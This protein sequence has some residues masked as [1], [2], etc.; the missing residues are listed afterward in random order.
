MKLSKTLFEPLLVFAFVVFVLLLLNS[1]SQLSF[2]YK[3][4]LLILNPKG[5]FLSFFIGQWIDLF[6]DNSIVARLPFIFFYSLSCLFIYFLMENYFTKEIDRVITVLIFALLPGLNSAALIINESIIVTFLVL[7]YLYL[8]KITKKQ[9]I[10]L[11]LLFLFIDNSFA[12]FYLALFF[13]SLYKKDNILLFVSLAL[14]G[15][16]M[17]IFGF[18]TGGKPKGY[19]IN[20][21]AIYASIFSPLLFMYF[22]YAMYKI[23]FKGKKSLYWFVSIT[24]FGFS[25]LLSFRQKP[26]IA[27]FAPFVVI[28]IPMMVKLF[29]HSYRVRLRQYRTKHKIAVNIVLT[30]LIINFLALH[31]NKPFYLLLENPTKHFAYDYHFT[32]EIAQKLKSK[33]ID[34][35]YCE[36]EKLQTKLKLYGIHKGN[37]Y[38]I[39][40]KNPISYDDKIDIYLYDK[41]ILRL[42]VTKLNS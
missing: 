41:V 13:Y 31:I 3:E 15:F 21:L 18:D 8:Y 39:T 23:S 14:F 20:T 30:I 33:N 24:A 35:I 34:F 12:I 42:F 40:T 17:S 32:K 27:D 29:M 4:S 22:T 19:F 11:L 10:P 16:S 26:D 25:L 28:A 9:N 2:S 1:S 38:Y 37:Q 7:F 6:G 36:D 5:S